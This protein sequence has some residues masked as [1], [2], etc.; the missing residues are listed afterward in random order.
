MKLLSHRQQFAIIVAL[1][2]LAGVGAQA[3]PR[4]VTGKNANHVG[5]QYVDRQVI[6]KLADNVSASAI[7]AVRSS[8]NAKALKRF[9]SIGAELWQIS[10][11]TVEAAIVR[12]RRD[13]R[14]KYV[15]PNYRVSLIRQRIERFPNDPRFAQMWGLHNTGQTGG[16]NDADID[17]PEAWDIETG[18][19]VIIGVIDTGIDWTHE[20]LAAN[21][22]INPGE[23]PNN[24]LDDD[25]NGYIDDIRGWDFVNNDNDPMDDEGHGSHVSGTIAA[26]GNNGIGTVGV[27]WS[28]KIMPLK[29]LDANG[30]GTTAGAIEAVE[31]ATRMHARL[32]SN[33]WGGGDFSQALYDAIA[34]AGKAGILFVAAAGNGGSDGIGDDNDLLPHYPLQL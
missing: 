28:A 23:I 15:E 30:N 4:F 3:Q 18:N 13:P 32:T 9:S 19:D 33:S 7:D 27:S 10:D 20:D 16:T 25:G 8:M 14:I 29:F 24:R 22:W 34:A 2:L 31:Y 12:Y 17:A 5:T 26:V 11:E 21:V 1:T 6:V